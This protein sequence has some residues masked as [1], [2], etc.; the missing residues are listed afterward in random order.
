MKYKT[1]PGVILTEICGRFFLVTSKENI[2]VNETTVLYWKQL[3]TGAS[4]ESLCSFSEE[5]F[6]IDNTDGIRE[7]IRELLISL[8]NKHLLVRCAA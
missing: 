6:E 7:D 1:S 5:I 4:F 2:E 3:E 8:V